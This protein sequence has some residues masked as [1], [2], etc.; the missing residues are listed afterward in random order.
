MGHAAVIDGTDLHSAR[1]YAQG[2]ADAEK[3]SVKLIQS[4]INSRFQ[5]ILSEKTVPPGF[6]LVELVHP[7]RESTPDA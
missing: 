4:R 5:I 6:A 3:T 2:Y 1:F 7:N